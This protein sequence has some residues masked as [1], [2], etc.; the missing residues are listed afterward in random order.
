MKDTTA[1]WGIFSYVAAGTGSAAPYGQEGVGGE[2]FVIFWKDRYLVSTTAL[3]PEARPG[4]DLFARRADRAIGPRGR[5]PAIA[6]LLLRPGFLN[7]EV[8]L[9]RGVLAFER[10]AELGI[11]DAFSVRAGVSGRIDGC[12]TLILEYA[13]ARQC[14]SLRALGI[15]TLKTRGTYTES[16]GAGG[17]TSY[18]GPRGQR[19]LLRQAGRFLLMVRGNDE[20]SAKRV[21]AQLASAVSPKGGL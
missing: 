12:R 15:G 5:R 1:A 21:A 10:G 9:V 14:D 2:D 20:R 7:T 19:L 13:N 3:S 6:E 16:T 8:F 4:L 11:G 18:I 17:W